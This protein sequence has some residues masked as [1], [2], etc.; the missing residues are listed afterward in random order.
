[1]YVSLEIRNFRCFPHLKINNLKRVNLI[2]GKNNVG[3]TA[4]LEAV[5]LHGGTSPRLT[6][7]LDAFR[8]IE[9]VKIELGQWAE[10][11]WASVFRDFDVSEPVCITSLS[12]KPKRKTRKV[13]LSVPSNAAELAAIPILAIVRA[14]VGAAS[15]AGRSAGVSEATGGRLLTTESAQVLK[16]ETSENGSVITQFLVLDV[17]GL[18]VTAPPPPPFQT[19]FIPSKYRVPLSEEAD[20]FG[21]LETVGLHGPIVEALRIIEP[22]L[23]RLAVVSVG[24][25]PIVHG[26]VGDKR[27]IP[28]PLMG[29]GIAKLASLLLAIGAATDGVVLVDEIENGFHYSVIAGIWDVIAAAAES[30]NVQVFATT[31]SWD[32]VVAAHRAYT[33]RKEYDF[34]YQRLDRVDDHSEAVHYPEEVLGAAAETGIEVR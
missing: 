32:C 13:R 3:K 8:G 4:L 31:H 7:S 28:L 33:L 11:P 12:K 30:Y 22:R 26:D 15:A 5:F 20:R 9:G 2:G 34:S 16:L 17:D 29:E 14:T 23:K 18:R 10:A 21:K 24:G 27:L 25:K 6:F 19:I 1:M